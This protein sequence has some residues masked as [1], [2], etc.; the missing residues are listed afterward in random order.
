MGIL[1][2]WLIC[3]GVTAAIASSKGR[4]GVGWF[5]IGAILGIFGIILIACLPSLK[6]QA[7]YYDPDNGARTVPPPSLRNLKKC[8]DCA[9]EVQA[10][11][12]ICKHCRHE[13]AAG[14]PPIKGIRHQA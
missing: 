11:A 7:T 10:E 14:P 5:L 12:R 2:I 1:V 3:A 9:E 4:S 8:P 13:F 6:P